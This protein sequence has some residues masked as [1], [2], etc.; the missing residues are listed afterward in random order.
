MAES[1]SDNLYQ[2]LEQLRM[3]GVA[4][5]LDGRPSTPEEIAYRCLE[6]KEVYMPDYVLDDHGILQ[7]LRYDKVSD[8]K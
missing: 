1:N 6:E 2:N 8:W 5:F 4:L 7:E 3:G